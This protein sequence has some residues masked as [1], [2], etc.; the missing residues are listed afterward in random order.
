MSQATT[1]KR[2]WQSWLGAAV[3]I[4]FLFLAVKELRVASV[5]DALRTA[6]YLWLVPAVISYLGA[7]SFRTVRWIILLHHDKKISFGE[8]LPTMA[9]GRAANNILPLRIGEGVRVYLLYRRNGV[10]AAVGAA[11][12][13]VERTFDGITMIIFLLVAAAI[14]G[15]PEGLLR[16]AFYFG[17]AVFGVALAGIYF[18]VIFPTLTRRIINWFNE[19]LVPE[20]FRELFTSIADHFINGFASVKSP[21]TLTMVLLSAIMVWVCELLM[22]RLVMN[23][24]GFGVSLH[25][26]LLMS[27]A[28]NLGTALPSGAANLGTFDTPGFW[29]LSNIAKI[30]ENIAGSYMLVLHAALWTTETLAGVWFMWRTGFT[31][32]KIE[33]EMLAGET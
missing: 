13:I 20:R 3:S 27:G 1:I 28:A 6:Q 15:I 21:V 5:W 24:F 4:V 10:H 29:V 31:R 25:H 8:L 30:N 17:V 32:Q 23:C 33:A 9:I 22:Y 16:Q 14:G 11:S 18:L 2:N 12:L 26:L 19:H 7:L